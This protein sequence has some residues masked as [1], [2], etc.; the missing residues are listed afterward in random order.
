MPK[1]H[2]QGGERKSKEVRKPQ[3]Q[4]QQK[5]PTTW[6]L[7]IFNAKKKIKKQTNSGSISKPMG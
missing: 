4:Q 2:R 3:Q 7:C 6:I 5:P 1:D